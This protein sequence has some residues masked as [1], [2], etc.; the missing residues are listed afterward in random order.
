MNR[1][2]KTDLNRDTGMDFATG[3]TE[4]L[5]KELLIILPT[6]GGSLTNRAARALIAQRLGRMV[7]SD[8]YFMARNQLLRDRVIGRVRGQGGSV[9]R[10]DGAPEAVRERSPD[11]AGKVP[12]DIA[13]PPEVTSRTI[14]AERDLMFATQR[15]LIREFPAEL[16]LPPG[17]PEPIVENISTTGPKTGIWARPDFVM[18]CVS[19]FSILPGF[20][21]E[22]HVFELK[23]ETGGGVR[24]VHE[25]LA[26]GRFANYAHLVWHVPDG[27]PRVAELDTIGTHCS[28]HGVGL[29]RM[30]LNPSQEAC[31][32]VLVEARRT[33]TSVLEV[34]GFL[35]ARL[36][37]ASKSRLFHSLGRSTGG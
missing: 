26:Q 12:D 17:S 10:L 2:V 25:A 3:E 13:P 4:R 14:I 34:D 31:L 6:D 8:A 21:V 32:E 18:V 23:N 29:I 5:A 9:F 27:S 7:S 37:D 19:R 22:T 15:A 35:E 30:R 36:S 16:D 33:A 11:V 1:V 20:H 24:A 28:L